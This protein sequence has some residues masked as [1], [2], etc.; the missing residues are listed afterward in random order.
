MMIGALFVPA[1]VLI[2]GILVPLGL[3]S[4]DTLGELF[5]HALWRPVAF[6]VVALSLF[7]AAHRLRFALADLGLRSMA[8]VLAF[9]LYGAALAGTAVAAAAAFGLGPVCATILAT[10][11]R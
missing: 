4:E 3:V 10:C 5:G 8:P 11:A 6:A 9:L 2:T 1:L 7:H